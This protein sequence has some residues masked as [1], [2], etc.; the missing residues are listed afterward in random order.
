MGYALL[1]EKP[2]LGPKIGR[3]PLSARERA[4]SRWGLKEK[5]PVSTMAASGQVFP[6][7]YF[8][9]ETNLAYNWHRYY[10]PE[11][12]RYIT[13]DPIGLDGGL[14]TYLYAEANPLRYTDPSGLLSPEPWP[15]VAEAVATATGVAASTVTAVVAGIAAALYPTPVGD[16]TLDGNRPWRKRDRW[17][18]Y[19]R[20]NVNKQENCEN[21]P[22]TIG[23]KAFGGTFSS[24]FASAQM[25]ANRNLG[26]Q[27]ARGCQAR[28]CQP[29]ACFENDRQVKCP[30]SGR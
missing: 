10:D 28:H 6:G 8:D 14:N 29:V 18:V 4:A 17:L 3:P 23:G 7:Q 15:A 5:P 21:C 9:S 1:K 22:D 13:S 30:K 12:D 19:V 20:C 25:D 27:G 24:A 2:R 16:A 26:D 11:L